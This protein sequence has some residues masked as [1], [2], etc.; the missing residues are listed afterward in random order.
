MRSRPE[1]TNAP[2]ITHAPCIARFRVRFPGREGFATLESSTQDVRLR[3]TSIRRERSNGHARAV[4]PRSKGLRW[5]SLLPGPPRLRPNGGH[6]GR[7][8]VVAGQHYPSPCDLSGHPGGCS[9]PGGTLGQNS[10]HSSGPD[11][12]P[13]TSCVTASSMTSLTP[14]GPADIPRPGG[15]PAEPGN[16]PRLRPTPPAF[17]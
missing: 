1:A 13:L 9:E 16:S 10:Y 14:Q 11:P 5:L 17:P 2:H 3:C 12:M 15:P 4:G 8:A 6:V 7:R